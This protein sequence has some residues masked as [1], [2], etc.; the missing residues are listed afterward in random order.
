MLLGLVYRPTFVLLIQTRQVRRSLLR[1]LERTDRS[2][3]EDAEGGEEE[4]EGERRP[5]ENEMS[6]KDR[7]GRFPAGER[8]NSHFLAFCWTFPGKHEMSL[9]NSILA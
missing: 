1:S 2:S 6:S 7:S 8:A 3:L 4:A 9:D 5:T